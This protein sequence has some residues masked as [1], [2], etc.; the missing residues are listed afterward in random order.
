MRCQ[1]RLPGT[2]CC[3]PT[4]SSRDWNDLVATSTELHRPY[5]KR[6]RRCATNDDLSLVIANDVKI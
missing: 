6:I 4:D 2:A 1:V 5:E 3:A